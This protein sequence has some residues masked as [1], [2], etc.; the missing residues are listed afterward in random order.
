MTGLDPNGEWF[1][2]S[3]RFFS[4]PR[5]TVHTRIQGYILLSSVALPFL[6][7]VIL[8]TEKGKRTWRG[9]TSLLKVLAQKQCAALLRVFCWWKLITWLH[10]TPKDDRLRTLC[11]KRRGN[12]FGGNGLEFLPQWAF[13]LSNIHSYHTYIEHIDPFTRE[14]TLSLLQLLLLAQS[15]AFLGENQSS[16]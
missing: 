10:L 5:K 8:P 14:T 12:G 15:L 7:Q 4:L 13:W 9:F 1:Q 2:Y 6:R 16:L 11:L 3:K